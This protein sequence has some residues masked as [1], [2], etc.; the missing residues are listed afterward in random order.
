MREREDG[1]YELHDIS[2][3]NEQFVDYVN[4]GSYPELAL[5]E[6]V[7]NH[8]E[9][10]IK[11]D[12]VDKV[13]LRDLPQLYGIQDIQ[14]LNALFTLLAYNTGEE[15][16]LEG[17]SQ[18]SGVGKPTITRYIE[19]LEAAFLL[20]RIF[21]IDQSGRRYKRERNFK[22]YLTNP[23][24]RTGLFG[25]LNADDQGF[26]HM[27]ET[28][29]YAQR[30]HENARLHYARWGRGDAFEIDMIELNP[31]LKP[32][33]A[34]EIKWGDRCVDHLD[35]FKALRKFSHTNK[36]KNAVISTRSKFARVTEGKV[37]F[38]FWPSACW[39][40]I[41]EHKPSRDGLLI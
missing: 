40:S 8:P 7:R 10:F 39:L 2:R 29:L 17:L 21:R 34:F 14:E 9:R 15:V 23:A 38:I 4:Y 25:P 26:G 37:Q 22:V 20:Q 30:F 24:M 28:A 16:S 32:V 18:R 1:L 35:E 31:L 12:I 41:W 36:L 3:L 33:E 13:L 6:D 11:S 5:S 27:V 19:Y